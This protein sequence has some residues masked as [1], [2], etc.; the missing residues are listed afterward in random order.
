MVRR[1]KESGATLIIALIMLVLLTLMVVSAINS[2]MINLR[3][4]GNMQVEDEA[5][6][7]AQQAIENFISSYANFYPIP[8][9][10]ST[11]GYDINNAGT[12]KYSVTVAAPVCKSASKQIPGRS[13]ACVNGSKSGLFCWDTLWEVRATAAD[14]SS[15]VSQT[16]VQGVALSFAPTFLPSTAGC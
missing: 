6:A 5:R 9:A 8:A 16:V 2:G 14:T 12:A 4:A 11:T 13:A 10:A 15:G 1:F 3:I 7:A